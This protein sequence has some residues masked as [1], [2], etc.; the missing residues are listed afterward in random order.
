M[1]VCLSVCLISLQANAFVWNEVGDAGR[2]PNTAQV[3]VGV[4]P[5][6][7]INGNYGFITD[8]DMY[9]IFISDPSVFVAEVTSFTPEDDDGIS[10]SQLSLFDAN[11]VY[12]LQDDDGGVGL[13]SKIDGFV[14]SAG[15]YFLAI[16]D[17]D[18]DPVPDT[19][20]EQIID[21]DDESESITTGTYE[22]ALEGA[23]AA[24]VP[25]V[26]TYCWLV[27]MLVG[28]YLAQRTSIRSI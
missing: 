25:S 2:L 9:K 11:G 17:F 15:N 12:I 10:D 19:I 1:S 22:I 5:L 3:P 6:T 23:T 24:S 20:G 4:G 18:N 14:G 16:S 21:W 13:L 27:L 26:T 28:L 8:V 7:Q